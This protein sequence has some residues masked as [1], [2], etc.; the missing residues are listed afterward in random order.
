MLERA[1]SREGK[2][3]QADRMLRGQDTL[4]GAFESYDLFFPRGFDLLR[5]RP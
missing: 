5:A 1:A 4:I 2:P 3:D